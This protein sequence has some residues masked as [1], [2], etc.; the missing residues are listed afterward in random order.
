MIHCAGCAHL[1]PENQM[2][3]YCANCY[4]TQRKLLVQ[5]D[6]SNWDAEVK[7]TKLRRQVRRLIRMMRVMKERRAG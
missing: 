2:A 3:H 1:N 7:I 5:M 6:R 4:R